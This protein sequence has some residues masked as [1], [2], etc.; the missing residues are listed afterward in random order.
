MLGGHAIRFDELPWEPLGEH[1]RQK[2]IVAQHRTV[3]L[4]QLDD[5]FH[6]PDW[7]RKS[8]LG[9]VVAGELQLTFA[10]RAETVRT[11][12][13][14][15]LTGG[16]EGRHRAAVVRGPVTVFLIESN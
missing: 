15:I 9:Y 4:L 8:H 16:V 14:L 13:A 1:A 11:G 3:R 12:D 2:Q 10:D 6:E 7:C 5:G